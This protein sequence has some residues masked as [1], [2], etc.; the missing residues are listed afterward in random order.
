MPT[1]L[2]DYVLP[3]YV[4][5]L[6]PALALL[7][8]GVSLSLQGLPLPSTGCL[9][10]LGGM[11]T[12]LWGAISITL[13]G[14][15]VTLPIWLGNGVSTGVIIAAAL[16]LGLALQL[17]LNRRRSILAAAPVGTLAIAFVLP[18]AAAVIPALDLLWLSR[19]AAG[20]V[21]RHHLPQGEPVLS[22]GYNEPSLVFL[23]GTATRLTTAAPGD[24]Q[25]AGAGLALVSE[26]D[27]STFHRSLGSRGL[28]PAAIERVS[29]LDYS[30]GGHRVTLT[31]YNVERR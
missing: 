5:P 1:K 10:R 31:P 13:T 23:L 30:A 18:A 29:G 11:V 17:L 19:T 16:V 2:P 9:R 20:L 26:R 6:Y 15:L 24:W 14:A 25:L 27:D 21:A 12:V 3:L 28:R 8:G 7:A 4:L 22:V